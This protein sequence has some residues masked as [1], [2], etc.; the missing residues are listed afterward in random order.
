MV[1]KLV[2]ESD[3]W[4]FTVDL[5]VTKYTRIMG[6]PG[7]FN[8]VNEHHIFGC[9][10]YVYLITIEEIWNGIRAAKEDSIELCYIYSSSKTRYKSVLNNKKKTKSRLKLQIISIGSFDWWFLQVDQVFKSLK[11]E[12]RVIEITIICKFRIFDIT[13]F[14]SIHYLDNW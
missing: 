7:F 4:V 6:S 1:S 14:H 5:E 13:V 8:F 2:E 12:T 11:F 3:E 9:K 10:N